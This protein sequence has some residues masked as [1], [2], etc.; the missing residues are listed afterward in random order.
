MA[1]DN[2]GHDFTRRHQVVGDSKLVICLVFR[3]GVDD[4]T[5]FFVFRDLKE[6]VL[7]KHGKNSFRDKQCELPKQTHWVVSA[8]NQLQ[9]L[10]SVVEAPG[11]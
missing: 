7:F 4:N 1:A 6:V 2:T 3:V 5:D 9:L 11:C 8:Y 10:P